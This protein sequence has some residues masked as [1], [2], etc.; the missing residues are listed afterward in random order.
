[1]VS[2]QQLDVTETQKVSYCIPLW[3]RDAQMA[4][5]SARIP[6]RLQP[7]MEARA[8]PVAVVCYGPSLADT[9]EQVREFP[10]VISCSGSH[11]FLVERGIIPTY[12]VE[13]DPRPHKVQLIGPPQAATTYLIAS[14]CHAAVFDHLEGHTVQLWHVF[15]SAAEGLRALPPG[16]WAVTGG[17]SVGLRAL[18]IA[19]FLGFRDLHVFGMD[20]CL[21]HSMVVETED[22]PMTIK[23]LV[24]S[25]Y[26]GRV[27]SLAT[28]GEESGSLRWNRVVR[29]WARPNAVKKAWV[30]LLAPGGGGR[31]RLT[32]TE[33]HPCAVVADPLA[34]VV[35]FVEA[36][37]VHGQYLVRQPRQVSG[38]NE[39]A[40]YS[41]EQTSVLVGTFLG[42]GSVDRNGCFRIVHGPA[43]KEY[44]DFKSCVL[45]GTVDVIRSGTKGYSPGKP[46]Y[47]LTLPTNGQ[48]QALR[49]IAYVEGAKSPVPVL[50]YVDRMALAFWYMDDGNLAV[51]HGGRHNARLYTCAF[52]SEDHA[53]L[54]RWFEETWQII[55]RVYVGTA[56]YSYLHFPAAYSERFFALVAPYVPRCMAHKLP[57]ALMAYA[58]T[59]SYGHQRLGYAAAQVT[60][61]RMEPDDRYHQSKLYDVEVERDHNFVANG[62]VVHNCEGATGKHA[63]EHPSQPKGH[64][65]TVYEGVEYR[66]TPS[67]L[68][69]AQSTWHELNQMPAVKATFY[70]EGLVQAMSR[71]YVPSP[72]LTDKPFANVVGFVKPML[73]SAEY[74]ALNRQL[75][76]E[77]AAYG[78]GGG[79]HAPTVLKLA[80]SVDARS[81]LDYGSGKSGL[82]KSMPYGITEYDPAV[83]GKDESPR[84]ADLVVCTDVLEH[85]EPDKLAF[86]LADLQRCTR[87][88]GYFVIHTGP[89]A[90]HLADGRNTHL[91][92]RGLAW[93]QKQLGRYFTIGKLFPRGAEI[94]AVVGPKLAPSPPKAPPKEIPTHGKRSG[95]KKGRARGP[96][97]GAGR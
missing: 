82:A 51:P 37:D 44:L 12:H 11:R 85:I 19:G 70:G 29:G 93:W 25:G 62:T 64:A 89:A 84:P 68:A 52:S 50:K 28:E 76:Q 72:K 71:N 49:R 10:F 47:R 55:P 87:K 30:S 40:L 27:L 91:I 26:T 45:D 13:V 23:K 48:T 79:K 8:E 20:G 57:P 94:H 38:H 34:P 61:V 60:D 4:A 69:A 53:V 22:G 86:V 3:L 41:T 66:T 58:G 88:V 59:H 90:K 14:T 46:A 56:G 7:V 92:Q 42:D 73:I 9:W 16:E 78:V 83:P 35:K 80:E 96:A 15:D 63:A 67:M 17:C 32:V 65:V 81:V 77:N 2:G 6:G 24:D 75:H 33:D 36:R 97:Q 1:M 31:R 95:S 43:Q 5:S 18:T 21:F 39:H 54:V 74:A